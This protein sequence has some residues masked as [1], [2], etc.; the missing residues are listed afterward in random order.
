MTIGDKAQQSTAQNE[1]MNKGWPLSLNDE[2]IQT[3]ISRF[4]ARTRERCRR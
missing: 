2:M 3:Q 4:P 1:Q